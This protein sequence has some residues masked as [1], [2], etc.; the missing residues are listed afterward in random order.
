MAKFNPHSWIL[1]AVSTDASRYFMTKVYYD[2]AA[3]ALVATDGRRLHIW[4]NPP[5]AFPE[6][7]YVE[8]IPKTGTIV[9]VAFDAQFPNW[10]RV[11]PKDEEMT[12]GVVHDFLDFDAQIPLFCVKAGIAIN[13]Q[14]IRDLINPTWTVRFHIRA[15]ASRSVMFQH[16]DYTAVIQPMT[17]D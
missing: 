9:P 15:R 11:V 2:K 13:C 8:I 16:E 5:V 1:K 17:I 6:S 10:R 12:E 7:T 4:R 14:Y 3:A